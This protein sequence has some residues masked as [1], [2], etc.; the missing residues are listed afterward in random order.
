MVRHYRWK[1]GLPG[2][3]PAGIELGKCYSVCNHVDE[4]G[5]KANEY[6]LIDEDGRTAARKIPRWCLEDC[7]GGES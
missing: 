6:D 7:S 3:R 2:D 1:L 4:H 5:T